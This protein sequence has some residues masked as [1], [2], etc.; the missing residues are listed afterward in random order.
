SSRR[1]QRVLEELLLTEREYVRSL[2]YILTH[3]LPLLDRA[4]VPQDLRGKRGVIFG[5]LEKLHDFH[6]H[7]FLPELEACE[8][9]AAMVARC[10]LRHSE[11]FGLYALYSK[12]K[13]QSDALILH[14][15]HDIFKRKQQELGD[16]MDLSSYLLR[17]IQRISKYS[18]LLQDVLTLAGSHRPKGPTQEPP[19]SPDVYVPDLRS[20]DWERERAE[21]QAAADLVQF[22]MRHGNDLLTM[23]AVRECD[24]NL[25]EQGQLVRQD[26]FTVSFRKKKCVRRVFLFED[27]IL[28]SKTKKTDTGNEVYVYKHSFKTSDVGMTHHSSMGSLCFEIWFR[29][30]KGR[31]PTRSERPAWRRR[32]PGPPTWRGSCG[33]RP[34]TVEVG[35]R[36]GHAL[37]FP[38]AQGESRSC[39]CR[40]GCSWEWAA[41]RS[42]TSSPARLLSVTEPSPASRL[43]EVSLHTQD[44]ITT[45]LI[46]NHSPFLS[47]TCLPR[48]SI[49]THFLSCS[50]FFTLFPSPYS[51]LC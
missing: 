16:L 36:Q 13:P 30:E 9:E 10:F 25:K 47:L 17:P 43:A 27:L 45:L 46:E 22:Q 2:G 23:D 39:A 21:I 48:C 49:L 6:S 33:I 12:N 31:T 14:R 38:R 42:W 8:R 40:R 51:L 15:P 41:S 20:S 35:L 50:S 7:Y 1:L 19:L 18:L 5:N 11:S 34:P 26:E 3:Y 32:K 24:V 44:G 28:F 29:R 37:T 4:D